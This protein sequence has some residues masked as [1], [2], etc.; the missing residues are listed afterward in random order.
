MSA[1]GLP[2]GR[3]HFVHQDVEVKENCAVLAGTNTLCGAVATMDKCVRHF[4]EAT[5]CSIV[6][7]LDAASLHPARSLGIQDRKGSLLYGRDADLIFLDDDLNVLSTWIASECVYQNSA[8]E[9]LVLQRVSQ[10]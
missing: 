7:A 10:N 4:K 8:F 5:G 1:L 9:P 2:P 6:E 3:Y